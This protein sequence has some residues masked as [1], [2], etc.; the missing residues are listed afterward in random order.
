MN[1]VTVTAL[2]LN[3]NLGATS[4]RALAGSDNFAI[5]HLR[6]AITL[7]LLAHHEVLAQAFSVPSW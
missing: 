2:S 6:A 4:T 5:G 7:L 1:S 3:A